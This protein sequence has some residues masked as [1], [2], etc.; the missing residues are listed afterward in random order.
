MF[1]EICL[2]LLSSIA[3]SEFGFLQEGIEDIN[4]IGI[5]DTIFLDTIYFFY[6]RV[7]VR[8]FMVKGF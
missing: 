4:G 5:F 7:K 3:S 8:D 2:V 1:F 6:H